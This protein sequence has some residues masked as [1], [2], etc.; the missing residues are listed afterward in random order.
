MFDAQEELGFKDSTKHLWL[1]LNCQGYNDLV[2][3]LQ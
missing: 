3:G 1:V 2:S